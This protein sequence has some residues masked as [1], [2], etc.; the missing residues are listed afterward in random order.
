M[1][2]ATAWGLRMGRRDSVGVPNNQRPASDREKV[3]LDINLLKHQYERLRER[4]RQAQIILTAGK[5][6]YFK[7]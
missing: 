5:K 7:I 4:Q 6:K 2:V 3:V 1:A